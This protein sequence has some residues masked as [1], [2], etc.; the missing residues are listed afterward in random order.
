MLTLCKFF[1]QGHAATCHEVHRQMM[2]QGISDSVYA[3]NRHLVVSTEA[4]STE[5]QQQ[6]ASGRDGPTAKVYM[7][8]ADS[9]HILQLIQS[10]FW[11]WPFAIPNEA[12]GP[13]VVLSEHGTM[14]VPPCTSRNL[15]VKIA[16][17]LAKT[18][19]WIMDIG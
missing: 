12:A 17:L 1:A 15:P 16:C 8:A 7:G 14:T 4:N 9:G 11:P 6:L 18:L 10:T 3:N 13:R 19:N 5:L 2:D